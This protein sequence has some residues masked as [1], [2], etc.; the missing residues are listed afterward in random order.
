V[1]SNL[2][3]SISVAEEEFPRRTSPAR[4]PRW[5][6]IPVRIAVI[7]F[8]G[9]LLV[10]AVSLLL[11]IVG[12][13]IASAIRGLPPDMRIAYRLIA[14]PVAAFA[15]VMIFIGSVVMEVRRYLK[16]RSARLD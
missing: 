16:A 3:S 5:Y 11:A 8:V 2:P 7:T 12:T 1:G 15:G 13:V 14:L 4:Y 6:G 9:T 10:F